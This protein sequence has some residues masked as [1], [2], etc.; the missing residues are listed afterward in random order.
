[1]I[2]VA[3]LVSFSYEVVFEKEESLPQCFLTGFEAL[4]A[5]INQ[6]CTIAV[7]AFGDKLHLVDIAANKVS[8]KVS[9]TGN[10]N[11]LHIV[12]TI[13]Y[14]VTN[15]DTL[16]VTESSNTKDIK[17]P[18]EA[19]AL[20][21]H[22]G[23]AYVGTKRGNFLVVELASGQVKSTTAISGS[24]IT[25][26]TVGSTKKIVGVGSSNGNLSIYSIGESK[27]LSTDLKYH[28]LPI[29]AILF[30]NDDTRCVTAAHERDMHYWNIDKLS[31]IDTIASML[32]LTKMSI[33]SL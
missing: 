29:T 24:K 32:M 13:V 5:S 19:T 7:T 28:N 8:G 20:A 15:R 18:E 6:D 4:H 1:M 14:T 33:R 10:I 12:D 22:N 31:H 25:R 3:E 26:V 23:F 30:T 9:I 27:M 16:T 17:L 21:V 2:R 11:Y